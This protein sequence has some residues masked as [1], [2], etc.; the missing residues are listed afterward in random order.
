M[1]NSARPQPR[2]AVLKMQAYSP[3]A[4][5]RAGKLRLDFNEN[6]AGCSPRVLAALQA[7]AEA[8]RLAVYPEYSESKPILAGFFGV[9][10]EQLLLTN[11]T[12][13]AVQ[14]FV[15]TYLDDR[16]EVVLLNPSYAMYRFYSELAGASVREIGYR[17]PDLSFPIDELLRAISAST[18]AVILAN[19]N[20]PTGTALELEA[21]EAILRKASPAAVLADE[22]YFEFCGITALPLIRHHPNLF[23]SRTFSKAYGLAG[24]RIAC[25]FSAA[26]NIGYLRKTQSPY[27]VNVIAASAACAAIS[28]PEHLRAY[29]SEVLRARELLAAGFDQLGIR[30][31]PSRANFILMDVGERAREICTLLRER[32]ILVRDRSYELPGCVRVTAGT[33]AQVTEFLSELRNLWR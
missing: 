18:R 19:P 13:E 8:D 20:N 21:L 24:L 6:T 33:Q 29:V 3:P 25:V 17:L 23:V 14:L 26:E 11:G 31:F 1:N 10:P 16:D 12:D 4:G 22:A 27:S 28:D 7:A 9:S 32:G 30:Y 5:A 15:N 2:S